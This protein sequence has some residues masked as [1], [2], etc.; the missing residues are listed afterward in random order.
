MSKLTQTQKQQLKDLV[1][2]ATVRRLTNLEM[3]DFIQS[4]MQVKIS[5]E[6]IRHLKYSIRKESFAQLK[7]YRADQMS[8][9]TEVFLE[10]VSELKLMKKT[11]HRIIEDDEEDAEAR[12]KAIAQ[13]QNVN[14]QMLT[15]YQYLPQVMKTL[16]DGASGGAG[17]VVGMGV[18]NN[19]NTNNN[20]NRNADGSWWCTGKCNVYHK[21]EF[22][23]HCP[24]FAVGLDA[25]NQ[26]GYFGGTP[27]PQRKF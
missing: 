13:L 5:G 16:D 1:I 3:S 6:Y 26:P 22:G 9:L 11:L 18:V 4:K 7:A 24:E 12:I 15:Y 21:D 10:P 17:V 25:E 27:D 23:K 19:N 2:D 8:Y 20:N 14:S